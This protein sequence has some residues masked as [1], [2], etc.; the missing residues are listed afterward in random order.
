MFTPGIG[1]YSDPIQELLYSPSDP[2]FVDTGALGTVC[3]Y[4]HDTMYVYCVKGCRKCFQYHELQVL[5]TRWPIL[6]SK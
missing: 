3:E 4:G 6:N 5:L 1:S 2:V